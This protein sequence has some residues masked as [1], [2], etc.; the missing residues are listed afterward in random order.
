MKQY[1]TFDRPV[2]KPETTLQIIVIENV[3]L[4]QGS[5]VATSSNKYSHRGS[6]ERNIIMLCVIVDTL[7]SL[8]TKYICT[9]IFSALAFVNP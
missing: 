3:Y 6:E 2:T 9:G 7:I 1:A 4:M 5:S 8:D